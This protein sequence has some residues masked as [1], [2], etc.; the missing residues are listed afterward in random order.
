M[1]IPENI[2][3]LAQRVQNSGND[4]QAC[5]GMSRYILNVT[6]KRRKWGNKDRRKTERPLEVTDEVRDEIFLRTGRRC[7]SEDRRS[8][9]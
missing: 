3:I 1:K 2:I 4:N 8:Y 9:E 5:L 7:G 6:Q